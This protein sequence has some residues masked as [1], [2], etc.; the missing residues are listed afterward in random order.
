[1]SKKV[2]AVLT[3]DTDDVKDI[4]SRLA[5]DGLEVKVL[6]RE[7]VDSRIA[8]EVRLSGI[9]TS[10]SPLIQHLTTPKASR[11][12]G[13]AVIIGSSGEIRERTMKRGKKVFTVKT[14]VARGVDPSILKAAK[15]EQFRSMIGRWDGS[16]RANTPKSERRK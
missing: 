12:P 7:D 2:V 9:S 8:E 6:N 3:D 1:M 16:P 13:D 4:V 11:R 15:H 5:E 10:L 14:H